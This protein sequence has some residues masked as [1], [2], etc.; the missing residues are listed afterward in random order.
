MLTRLW[1]S[2]I[3]SSLDLSVRATTHNG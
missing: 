1:L 3:Y 2:G